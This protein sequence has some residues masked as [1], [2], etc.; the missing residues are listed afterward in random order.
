ME[1][2]K[3]PRHV[4]IIPD[5]NG[6]W[7]IGRNLPRMAGHRAGAKIFPDVVGWAREAGI[8]VLSVF[9]FSTE[10]WKRPDGE[11]RG[12]M[13]IFDVL[14]RRNFRRLLREK[15]RFRWLGSADG[16]QR[17]IVETLRAMEL[18]TASNCGFCLCLAINYSGR[19]EILRAVEK[20]S[21]TGSAIESWQSLSQNLDS[22]GLPDVDLVVRTSGERRLSNFLLLQSAYAELHFTECLWPD[23]SREELLRAIDE[24]GQRKRRFGA[25]NH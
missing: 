9:C 13:R 15:I 12:L 16:L 10:N 1:K 24:Y 3:I 20:I 8:E 22:S 25:I 23:F 21:A 5:G 6:R 17:R 2:T 14:L 11:V 19:D 7:A 18:E 4:A